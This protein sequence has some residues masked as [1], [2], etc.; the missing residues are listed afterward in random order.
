MAIAEKLYSAG[1]ISYPRTETNIFP[2]GLDLRPLVEAQVT[3]P[4]WGNFAQRVLVD[5]PN[6]RNGN[7]TDQAHPPIHPIQYTNNLHGNEAKIYEF[8]VRHFL[9]CVSKVKLLPS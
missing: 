3:D 8:V 6:P 2:K 9:A 1:Y 7:K 5:G 4:R